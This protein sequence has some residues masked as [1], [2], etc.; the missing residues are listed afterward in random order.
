M[1]ASRSRPTE[2]DPER[3]ARRRCDLA[4]LLL[5]FHGMPS[6]SRPSGWAVSA[7]LAF[8]ASIGASFDPDRAV[9][10]GGDSEGRSTR[11][12]VA[13]DG[14]ARCARCR[15]GCAE[16][17]VFGPRLRR[18]TTTMRPFIPMSP[19]KRLRKC[20]LDAASVSAEEE[21]PAPS[22]VPARTPSRASGFNNLL[23]VEP[24]SPAGSNVTRRYHSTVMTHRAHAS[25]KSFDLFCFV[26]VSSVSDGSGRCADERMSKE[27]QTLIPDAKAVQNRRLCSK[28]IGDRYFPYNHYQNEQVRNRITQIQTSGARRA[29]DNQLDSEPAGRYTSGSCP[30]RKSYVKLSASS[31]PE[32]AN[33]GSS[34]FSHRRRN[35]LAL[36]RCGAGAQSFS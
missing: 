21:E 8:P 26:T 25:R 32:V 2:F 28:K 29:I 11:G 19:A 16:R 9:A 17:R 35:R 33:V 36:H 31:S 34:A 10:E 24:A 3:N 4:Q 14:D 1:A 13:A 5:W 15:C 27:C 7:R 12:E 30:V 20:R 22:V 18:L 6:F 23:D